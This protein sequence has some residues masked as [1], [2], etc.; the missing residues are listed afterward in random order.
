MI[1]EHDMPLLMGLC[2]RVYAMVEGRVVAEG[3]PEE[4]R[5]DPAV[6]ASY[7]GT[8][9]IAIARSGSRPTKPAATKRAATKRATTNGE[10]AA[11]K[12]QT[13]EWPRRPRPLVAASKAKGNGSR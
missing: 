1:V 3:T 4:I 11:P 12:A 10:A 5:N 2:D 7:L 6:I 9:E 8:D 13:S